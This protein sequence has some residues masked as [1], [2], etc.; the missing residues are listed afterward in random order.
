MKKI[1][2]TIIS[3]K[4]FIYAVSGLIIPVLMTKFSWGEDVATQVWHTA[5]V[6]I[7]G[8]GIADIKK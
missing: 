1:L 3:S 7:L 6:L 4:K 8:Q 2:M 5:L